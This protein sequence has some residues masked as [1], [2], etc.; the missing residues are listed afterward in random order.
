MPLYSIRTR[1]HYA[2]TIFGLP[3]E[4]A[5]CRI[6]FER[7]IPDHNNPARAEAHRAAVSHYRA[8][9][10]RMSVARLG[11]LSA[12]DPIN[13]ARMALINLKKWENGKSL[14]CR[15]LDGETAWQTKVKKKA[16]TWEQFANIKLNFVS[17]GDAEIRISF[18][19][20]AGSWSA[21]GNDALVESYFPKHQPT[22][23]FGWLRGDTADTEYE[24]VVV[25]EFGHALGCIHEH[26]SPTVQLKWDKA[27]VY[28]SFSGPPNF[29]SKADIDHNVLQKYSPAGISATPFDNDSI[30]LY[31][32]SAD[33]F[34]DHKGTPENTKLSPRDKTMIAQMYPK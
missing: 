19:A 5:M 8:N 16:K 30:M 4:A 23:N 7:I 1:A 2:G 15:F 13:V 20:D 25:H 17:S 6:C 10:R 26:Q 3:R 28:R 32:F 11:N 31:Q 21:I 14:K 29:W 12:G 33:L 9:T 18:F 27:A 24:R 22:M 34:L